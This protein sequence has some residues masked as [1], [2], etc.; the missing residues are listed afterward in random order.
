MLKE[1]IVSI[2]RESRGTYGSPRILAELT[3]AKGIRTSKKRIERLMRESGIQGISRRRYK[4][5]TR[6]DPKATLAPDLVDRK[7]VASRPNQLWVAEVVEK[8][9]ALGN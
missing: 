6:R 7:F 2:H 9:Q 4:G 8:I 5:T 1:L 3:I